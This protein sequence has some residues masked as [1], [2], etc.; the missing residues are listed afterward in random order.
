LPK[1]L[2][3]WLRFELGPAPLPS[4][5]LAQLV[6]RHPL[7]LC[8]DYDGTLSEIATEPNLARPADGVVPVLR[9]LVNYRA[10]IAL[11]I[12]SGRTLDDLRALLPI[13]QGVALAGVHGLEL[14]DATGRQEFAHGVREC[15]PDLQRARV[16]LQRNLP[17]SDGFI[18]EDKGVALALHYRRAPA[19]IA[20]HMRSSFE[21]FI[22]EC[23]TA[24]KPRHG[25]MV[26]EAVPKMATKAHAVR[27]LR[28]G[29]GA[30]FQPVYFGDDL[31]DEDAFVELKKAG[32]TVLVGKRRRSEARYRVDG[33]A[34][35]VR[36]LNTVA[37]ALAGITG[38]Q[39]ND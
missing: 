36:V 37:A 4:D 2:R 17:Q 14:L 22:S 1:A 9:E 24:L 35:V 32:I 13:P 38:E 5:L 26:L 30:E 27:T 10:R 25:K 33:P 31:T 29:V 28:Q 6:K 3:N 39:A 15:E 34:D 23:T 20:Q 12:V 19:P 11:A 8:L 21:Q 7:L 18:V 16:W